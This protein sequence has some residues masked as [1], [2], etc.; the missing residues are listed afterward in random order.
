MSPEAR[1]EIL[2]RLRSIEGHVRGIERMLG[3]GC[4]CVDLLRQTL[5]VR[6]ALDRVSQLLV[7]SQL[8]ACL[9]AEAGEE[10]SPEQE[11]TIDELLEL[12]DL[13]NYR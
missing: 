5:A 4:A 3:E 13:A 12:L 8:R 1:E 10:I 2:R 9:A 6:R 7:S 11:Q